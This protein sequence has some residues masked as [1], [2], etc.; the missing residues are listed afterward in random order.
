MATI[1][2]LMKHLRESGTEISG[3]V[4]KRK[5]RRIGYYHGYKGYR[6]AGSSNNRLPISDYN[7]VV[8]LYE[9]DTELK[10][11]FMDPSWPLRRH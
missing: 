2:A 4:Q 5:L 3:S 10:S 8:A 1:N 11:F 7:Q 6:F 9:F